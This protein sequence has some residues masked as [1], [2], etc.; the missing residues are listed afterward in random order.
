M[1]GAL[2]LPPQDTDRL[3]SRLYKLWVGWYRGEIGTVRG[4]VESLLDDMARFGSAL[5]EDQSGAWR[6]R[7]MIA[8]E[9]G[10]PAKAL[11]S[12]QA[13]LQVAESRLGTRHNQS[14]LGLVDLT[15]AY[16]SAGDN[17]RGLQT[18]Q[19][20]WARGLAAYAESAS[21]PN[22]LKARVAYAEA[23]AASGN[24]EAAIPVAKSAIG[25]TVTLFGPSS[26]LEGLSLKKLAI[27][28]AR[29]GRQQDAEQ[30][31]ERSCEILRKHFRE[32]SPASLALLDLRREIRS[33]QLFRGAPQDGA[34]S[35]Q[36]ADHAG[37]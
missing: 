2:R 34:R 21:H 30:S 23:L 1:R 16:L 11:S 12:A 31:M 27:I 28:E 15:Y 14:V 36:R 32:V 19:R 24:P 10:D 17:Q 22:V 29:A 13:A 37:S 33:G 5:P 20:A 4:P 26:L 3:R 8:V 7:S 18:A 9:E 35:G 25:D 6:I